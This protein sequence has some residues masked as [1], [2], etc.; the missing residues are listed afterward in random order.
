M[1]NYLSMLAIVVL[2]FCSTCTQKEATETL[3]AEVPVKEWAPEDVRNVPGLDA[4]RGVNHKYPGCYTRLHFV[5]PVRRF[6]YLVDE[7]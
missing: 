5:S 2:L 7:S 4:K 1:N 6:R 3:A